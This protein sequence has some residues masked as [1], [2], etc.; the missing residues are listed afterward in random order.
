MLGLESAVEAAVAS[1]AGRH[2][3]A[4]GPR[5]DDDGPLDA[6]YSGVIP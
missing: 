2:Q 6:L 5:I 4:F 3:L 1:G